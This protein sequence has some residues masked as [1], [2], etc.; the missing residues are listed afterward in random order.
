MCFLNLSMLGA[1][2]DLFWQKASALQLPGFVAKPAC[3]CRQGHRQEGD[4]LH[5]TEEMKMKRIERF[6]A[7]TIFCLCCVISCFAP[8]PRSCNPVL[9]LLYGASY[10]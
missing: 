9:F 5:D 4:A 1:G 10:D 6:F 2:A 3:A 7:V 8:F